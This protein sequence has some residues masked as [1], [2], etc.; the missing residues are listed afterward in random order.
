MPKK[1]DSAELIVLGALKEIISSWQEFIDCVREPQR[2]LT[3]DNWLGSW[4]D[5]AAK[6]MKEHCRPLESSL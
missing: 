6:H 5:S 4:N 1:D 3:A 2:S